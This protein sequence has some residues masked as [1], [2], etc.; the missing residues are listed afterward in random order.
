MSM[1]TA[2]VGVM[3]YNEE[4]NIGKLLTALKGLSLE[5]VEIRQ[6]IVVSSGSTDG[7]DDIVAE[8][9]AKDDRISLIRQEQR[10]GKASAINLFLDAAEADIFVLESGDTIPAP[11]C[12]ERMLAPFQSPDVGMTGGRPVP[13]DDPN[14]FMGFVVHMLWRL[15]HMLALKSPK[16][17]EMVAFRSFVRSIPPD[18][19]V[20]EASIEALVIDEG[21]SLAYADDAIVYNKG[22][23]TVG[24]FLKQ[25][26]RIYAGHI[27][28]SKVQSY[29]VST[30]KVGGI[31]SVLLEDLKPTPRT[32]LWTAGGVFLEF[33][34]RL[35]GAIDYHVLKKNPYT[36]EVSHST[37]N[38]D[39]PVTH[40]SGARGAG[41]LDG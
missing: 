35:L 33:V 12:V 20:D 18:T 8:C 10:M 41:A 6:I 24:D 13:V 19:A 5:N 14:T 4:Q 7:T 39:A 31:L 16:L 40:D 2:S 26:R 25:R 37:K 11:D 27:W 1:L 17:G 15:H 32:L 21:L 36:W 23:A 34:G 38:L 29:E 3:A 30:K 9:A 28:L 22:A